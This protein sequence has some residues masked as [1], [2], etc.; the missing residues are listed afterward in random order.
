MSIFTK[1]MTMTNRK[2]MQEKKRNQINVSLGDTMLEKLKKFADLRGESVS[3]C[4]R[5]LIYQALNKSEIDYLTKK[6][7]Q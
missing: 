4:V 5:T 6:D 7:A 1:L 3:R 2:K